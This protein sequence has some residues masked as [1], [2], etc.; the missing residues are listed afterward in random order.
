MNRTIL[1][2]TGFLVKNMRYF[3]VAGVFIAVIGYHYTI[4]APILT[5]VEDK[6]QNKAAIEIPDLDAKNPSKIYENVFQSQENDYYR[7]GAYLRTK[8][9][10]TVEVFAKSSFDDTLKIGEWMIEPSDNG[11]YEELVFVTPGRYEDI[12]IG[13]KGS[14]DPGEKNTWGGSMVFVRSLSLTRVTV[15]NPGAIRN[16][17]PT[18]FGI[19]QKKQKFLFEDDGGKSPDEW[20]F[21]A[22]GDYLE[23]IEFSGEIIGSGR[24]EYSFELSSINKETKEKNKQTERNVSFILDALDD[25]QLPSGDYRLMFLAPLK[26]GEWYALSLKRSAS[27]DTRNFFKIGTLGIKD[28]GDIEKVDKEASIGLTVGSWKRAE[29]GAIFPDYARLEDVGRHSIYSYANQGNES[30]FTNLFSAS[31]GVSFDRQKNLVFGQ[32]KKGEYF[33]YRFDTIS[34]FDRLVLEAIQHRDDEG[35]I[36]LAYSFDEKDWHEIPYAQEK[37]APQ[38]FLLKLENMT[39]RHILFVRVSYEGVE[40]KSSN[41]A[42]KELS[43]H[44]SVPEGK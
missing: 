1:A 2:G 4:K 16:L 28:I 40:K 11:E 42:L 7:V 8:K 35:E 33:T 24:Q 13:L 41:F 38:K 9:K 34:D 5:G 23:A 14:F 30:D 3:F 29:N 37:D 32:H 39:G 19:S 26:K 25:Y 18:R 20:I 21:Q 44:A 22:D 43:V 6:K 31:R 12:L 27:Q 15:A 36:K 17:H 10:E